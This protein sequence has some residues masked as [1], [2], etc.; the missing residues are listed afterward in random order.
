M[1]YDYDKFSEQK[2]E[3]FYAIYQIEVQN[4]FMEDINIFIAN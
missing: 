4:L 1:K 2:C 3:L